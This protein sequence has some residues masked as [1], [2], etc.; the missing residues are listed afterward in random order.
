M[1]D[2]SNEEVAPVG[3]LESFILSSCPTALGDISKPSVSEQR[4]SLL[5]QKLEEQ[6]Q[7]I[8]ELRSENDALKKQ[9]NEVF[10]NIITIY[11]KLNKVNKLENYNTKL[12]QI[13]LNFLYHSMD[14]QLYK[15]ENSFRTLNHDIIRTRGEFGQINSGIK[16]LLK[17]NIAKCKLKYKASVDGKNKNIFHMKCDDILYQLFI[18]K[19]TNN[20]RFGVFFCNKEDKENKI[21]SSK[22]IT[23]NLTQRNININN[24]LNSYQTYR[25]QNF[26][27][28]NNNSIYNNNFFKS[29]DNIFKYHSNY[30]TLSADF[31]DYDIDKTSEIFNCKNKPDK[32][33]AFSL[34]NKRNYFLNNKN[35]DNTPCFTINFDSNRESFYGKEKR[36]NVFNSQINDYVL[37]GREEFNILEFEVY[38][39]EI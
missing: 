36:I 24:Q 33:F 23:V 31:K 25:S 2:D 22:N 10:Q 6:G 7:Q 1:E 26:D 18:I 12:D 14:D 13:N 34:N 19:T 27:Y 21:N 4:I 5:E 16:N 3:R 11:N 39:I 38:E 8:N 32:F 9:L 29:Q 35:P 17:A 20:R 15:L 30:N 28:M 37:S